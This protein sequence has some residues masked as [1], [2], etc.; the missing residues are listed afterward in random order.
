MP[1]IDSRN[2]VANAIEHAELQSWNNKGRYSEL[3]GHSIFYIDEGEPDKPA[4]LLIHGFPTSSWDWQAIWNSLSKGYRLISLD[5]LGFGFSASVGVEWGTVL[6]L[7]R[8][9]I[10]SELVGENTHLTSAICVGEQQ[11]QIH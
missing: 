3:C 1:T 4:I 11:G 10:R 5:M 7:N 8:R 6:V 9:S 2:A